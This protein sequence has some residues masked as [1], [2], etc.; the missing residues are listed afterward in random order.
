MPIKEPTPAELKAMLLRPTNVLAESLFKQLVSPFIAKARS[1]MSQMDLAL[2]YAGFINGCL[3]EMAE[4]FAPEV[5]LHVMQT[6]MDCIE[7][8]A[9]ETRSLQ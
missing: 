7:S 9:N 4:D 3:G 6:Q 2:L 8:A 1:G 5:L